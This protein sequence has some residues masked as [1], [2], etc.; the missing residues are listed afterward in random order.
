MTLANVLKSYINRRPRYWGKAGHPIIDF[1]F[2]ALDFPNPAALMY[3]TSINM[4]LRPFFDIDQ[5]QILN[6]GGFPDIYTDVVCTFGQ[7]NK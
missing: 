6:A 1:A 3:G 4:F 5:S 2:S 7:I